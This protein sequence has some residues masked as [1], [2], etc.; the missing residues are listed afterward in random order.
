MDK[1]RYGTIEYYSAIKKE[2]NNAI[3]SNMDRRR[4]YHTE[5][6]KT[7]KDKYHLISLTSE[8]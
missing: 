3:C 8:I 4:D 6:S 7:E 1:K 2:P 5:W